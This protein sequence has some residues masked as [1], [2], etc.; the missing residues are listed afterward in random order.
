VTRES[1]W[2]PGVP[3]SGGEPFD[4]EKQSM[5]AG[6]YRQTVPIDEVLGR[7]AGGAGN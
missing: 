4:G 7:E 6:L 3:P 5:A 1:V 2:L